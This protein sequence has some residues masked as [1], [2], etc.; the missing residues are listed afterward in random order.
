MTTEPAPA[1]PADEYEPPRLTEVDGFAAM[2]RGQ[3]ASEQADDSTNGGYW[4]QPVGGTSP[5]LW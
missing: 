1:P 2:T 3:Y 4:S 5:R